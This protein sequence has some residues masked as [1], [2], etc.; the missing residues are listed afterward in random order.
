M[1]KVRLFVLALSVTLLGGLLGWTG[2]FAGARKVPIYSVERPDHKIA[3]SFDAAWGNE[4]TAAILRILEEY[5]VKTTFFLVKFWAEKFPDDVRK[6]AAAGHEVESHSATHP[7]MAKLSPQQIRQELETTGQVI[8]SLTGTV[9]QLFRPPFGS[10]NNT[11]METAEACGYQVIQ[12]SRDGLATRENRCNFNGS[13]GNRTLGIA[14]C[15]ATGN[16][17]Y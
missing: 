2:A 6:I 3:I 1:K 9:P 16:L 5:N 11:L 10:Y 8:E 7:D 15:K 13:G 12:W 4:H 14:A 17:L